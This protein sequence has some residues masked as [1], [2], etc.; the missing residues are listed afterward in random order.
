MQ[1]LAIKRGMAFIWKYTILLITLGGNVLPIYAVVTPNMT[2]SFPPACLNQPGGY[3][4]TVRASL[5]CQS[6]TITMSGL[7]D[8]TGIYHHNN[9]FVS[10]ADHVWDLSCK[11][12]FKKNITVILHVPC[13]YYYHQLTAQGSR[14]QCK[15]V[16][17]MCYQ[18]QV[19]GTTCRFFFHTNSVATAPSKDSIAV[20][21]GLSTEQT[22]N[23]FHRNNFNENATQQSLE[24]YPK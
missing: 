5:S 13:R 10:I 7:G 21:F 8:S 4:S 6:T 16:I 3:N 2:H 14:K 23:S 20:S 18:F 11:V 19:K 9:L 12:R 22:L 17:K 15:H 1:P 24:D